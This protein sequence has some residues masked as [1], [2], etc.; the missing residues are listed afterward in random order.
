MTTHKDVSSVVVPEEEAAKAWK[1]V[2][3]IRKAVRQISEYAVTNEKSLGAQKSMR[4]IDEAIK[5]YCCKKKEAAKAWEVVRAARDAAQ[6]FSKYAVTTEQ[7]LG[8]QTVVLAIDEVIA[9]TTFS[10]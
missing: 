5:K 10:R 6:Q 1:V 8:A 3:E 2:W 9:S 7:V 4:V